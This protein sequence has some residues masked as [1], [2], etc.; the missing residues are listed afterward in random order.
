LSLNL[1]P[2]APQQAQD[3]ERF[4]KLVGRFSILYYTPFYTTLSTKEN[5]HGRYE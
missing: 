2:L 4:I 3:G 1:D 5:R